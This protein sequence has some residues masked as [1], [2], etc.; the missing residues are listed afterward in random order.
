[1]KHISL[2]L[3]PKHTV[4]S[5]TDSLKFNQCLALRLKNVNLCQW[6]LISS[7]TNFRDAKP[8]FIL[9]I[10]ISKVSDLISETMSRTT[11]HSN[12]SMKGLMMNYPES[13]PSLN[14]ATSR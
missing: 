1:M 9:R 5:S 12:Y 8:A 11:A 3:S 13:K 2:K 7:G 10:L 6:R 4:L 14:Q